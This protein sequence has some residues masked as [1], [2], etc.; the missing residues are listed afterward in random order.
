MTHPASRTLTRRQALAMGGA[1]AA[2]AAEPALLAATVPAAR[3]I[4]LIVADD[5]G[6][7][8]IGANGGTLPTPALNAMARQGVA[9]GDFHAC[10]NVCTP[11][12]AG[13]LTGR[14]P[15][16]TGLGHEVLQVPDTHGLPAEEITLGQAFRASHATAL[17]GKWHL[18]HLA[19]HWPPARFGFDRFFGLKYSN[20]MRPL[21]LYRS[22]TGDALTEEPADQ[23]R[24]TRQFFDE[25]LRFVT[26]NRARPF[27]LTL[28]PTAPHLPL[29]PE[30]AGRSGR[31]AYGDVVAELD[32]GMARLFAAL[33]DLRLDGD[34]LVVFTS[35]N[36]PWFEGSAG[37]F[38]GRKGEAGYEGGYRVPLLAR[39]PGRLPAGKTRDA[40]AMNIDLFPTLLAAAGVARPVEPVIDGRDIWGCWQGGAASPHEQLLY[41]D[42]ERLA[43][44]RTQRWKLVG[45][46]HYRTY[47]LPLA[48]LGLPLLFD[49]AADPGENFDVAADQPAVARDLLARFVAARDSFEPLGKRQ[50]PDVLPTAG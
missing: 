7:G 39:L 9:M 21:A 8:D 28:M 1:A 42:N 12:R 14:Y 50:R 47:N 30:R 32:E 25:A 49:L 41:F 45:R 27:F 19:P 15:I 34:T 37:P 13:L 2:V 6:W 26:D 29:R 3:N 5:L 16:R 33:K 44:L 24:L 46:A 38:R 48:K 18:G 36:G 11:S 20:D 10:A 22:G 31:G 4:I 40:M 23:T 43:A 17:I 35:D